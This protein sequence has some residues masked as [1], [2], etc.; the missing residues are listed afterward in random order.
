MGL[1]AGVKAGRCAGGSSWSSCACHFCAACAAAVPGRLREARATL[2]SCEHAGLPRLRLLQVLPTIKPHCPAGQGRAP[3]VWRKQAAGATHDGPHAR[4]DGA[5]SRRLHTRA[6]A[7]R[8]VARRAAG[9]W[10]SRLLARRR[11]AQ[12]AALKPTPPAYM[13]PHC[14]STQ[15]SKLNKM[16][17]RCKTVVISAGV[18]SCRCVL[19]AVSLL[20]STMSGRMSTPWHTNSLILTPVSA[21]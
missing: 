6:A 13:G 18:A 1:Q 7:G 9:H 14:P 21:A 19:Q 20:T 2:A 10:Q 8:G 16:D 17:S 15:P 12:P 4:V 3:G 5:P 11:Q